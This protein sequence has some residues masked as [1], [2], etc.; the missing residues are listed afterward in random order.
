M[1][2]VV[3]TPGPNI[4]VS[5]LKLAFV[6]MMSSA[7]NVETASAFICESLIDTVFDVHQVNRFGGFQF[8]ATEKDMKAFAIVHS[9]E[10][11]IFGQQYVKKSQD[12][13]FPTCHRPLSASR[14][15]PHLG[16]CLNLTGQN[17]S[18]IASLTIANNCKSDD[19]DDD[20]Y[21]IAGQEKIKIKRIDS[22]NKR[23]K[24]GVRRS[25]NHKVLSED[26]VKT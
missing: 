23:D 1:A 2:D 8:Q 19:D 4:S 17:S 21:W 9:N 5:N 15:A 12:C 6:R 25:K 3:Y 24:N 11:D 10:A 7:E 22:K 14:F 20:D 26:Y 13:C 18:R 16:N